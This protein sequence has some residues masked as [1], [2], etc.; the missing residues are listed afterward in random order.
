SAVYPADDFET[1]VNKVV[2]ALLSGPA[3]A[4]AKT[5]NAINAATLTELDAAL[6]RELQGQSVLLRS[7][8]FVEGATAF[9]QRRT[10]K[11]TDTGT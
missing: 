6:E 3:V 4:F 11:F 9:Q 1:E 7:H 8:D 2:A 5:K 10:P